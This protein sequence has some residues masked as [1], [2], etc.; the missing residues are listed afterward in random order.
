MIVFGS[1]ELVGQFKK[2]P[3]ERGFRGVLYGLRLS[4]EIPPLLLLIDC[5]FSTHFPPLKRG[6]FSDLLIFTETQ[7]LLL[8]KN[9]LLS[10]TII[11]LLKLY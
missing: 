8:T 3:L 11:Q 2:S 10:A 7:D 9:N 6:L 5:A 4:R 1:H